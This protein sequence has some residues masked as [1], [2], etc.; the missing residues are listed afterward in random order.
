MLEYRLNYSR[1]WWNWKKN[2]RKRRRRR[3]LNL[4]PPKIKKNQSIEV[5]G[6]AVQCKSRKNK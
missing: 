5:L 1:K 4:P 2:D 6:R 3:K